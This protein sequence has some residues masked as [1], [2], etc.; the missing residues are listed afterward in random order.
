MLW[1][2]ELALEGL[3]QKAFAPVLEQPAL[4]LVLDRL[5]YVE[6]FKQLFGGKSSIKLKR[7]TGVG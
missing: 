2:L 7:W 3:G 4:V 5:E 6:L 1:L